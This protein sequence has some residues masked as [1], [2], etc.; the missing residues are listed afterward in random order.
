MNIEQKKE[1]YEIDNKFSDEPW[2]L[3]EF[4]SHIGDSHIGGCWFKCTIP[5]FKDGY[6]NYKRREVAPNWKTKEHITRVIGQTCFDEVAAVIGEEKAAEELYAAIIFDRFELCNHSPD[7]LSGTFE[8]SRSSQ[9]YDFWREISDGNSPYKKQETQ[10]ETKV[11]EYIPKVGEECLFRIRGID[12]AHDLFKRA[13]IKYEDKVGYLIK[14][15]DSNPFYVFKH[16]CLFKPLPQKTIKIN[17]EIP[18]P[19]T[20]APEIGTDYYLLHGEE[21]SWDGDDY[22]CERLMEGMVYI[23]KADRDEAK[24]IIAKALMGGA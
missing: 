5:P 1:Q 4:N 9:G 14:Q 15:A 19:E 16:N 24:R 3:W 2:K 6:F 11:E 20:D 12:F 10:K 22:D 18:A 13:R 8:W 17:C 23:N 21:C 7:D